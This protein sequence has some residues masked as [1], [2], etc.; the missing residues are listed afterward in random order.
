MPIFF[1]SAPVRQPLVFDSIGNNW[2]QDPTRRPKGYPLFHYLQT[3]SGQG[4]IWI[5]GKSYILNP[6]EGVLIS[7]TGEPALL[8]LPVLWRTVSAK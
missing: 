7:R 3:E 5:Q 2:L 1:R 4:E 6:G 8:H